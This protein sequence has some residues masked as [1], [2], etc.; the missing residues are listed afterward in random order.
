MP[1]LNEGQT[2]PDFSLQTDQGATVSLSAL[3]DKPL[4]LF[5]YIRNSTPG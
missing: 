5:F 1:I 4:V 2:A 3:Q